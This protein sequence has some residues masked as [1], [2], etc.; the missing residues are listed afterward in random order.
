MLMGTTAVVVLQTASTAHLTVLLD[1]SH[2]L[3]RSILRSDLD[4]SV[5]FG[6]TALKT[7]EES[8]GSPSV[9]VLET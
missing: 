2:L 9:M 3:A 4:A 7:S 1:A 8:L 5:V 6:P